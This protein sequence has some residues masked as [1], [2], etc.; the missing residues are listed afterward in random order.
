MAI[1]TVQYERG[2]HHY[3]GTYHSKAGYMEAQKQFQEADLVDGKV[4]KFHNVLDRDG[5]Y[6]SNEPTQ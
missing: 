2:G 4:K 1:L 3:L 6:R 5:G